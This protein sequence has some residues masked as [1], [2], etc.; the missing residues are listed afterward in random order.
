MFGADPPPELYQF[1]SSAEVPPEP[2]DVPSRNS[3]ALLSL[4]PFDMLSAQPSTPRKSRHRSH[5]SMSSIYS[6]P[7]MLSGDLESVDPS[8]TVSSRPPPTPPPFSAYSMQPP[9]L[10]IAESQPHA[11]LDLENSSDFRQRRLRAAKLSRFFGVTYQDIS[12]FDQPGAHTPRPSVVA[13]QPVPFDAPSSPIDVDVRIAEPNR[14][15]ARVE[16]RETMREPVDMGAVIHKLR[17]MR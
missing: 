14:F 3:A 15:W 17:T 2:V 10:P 12:S 16:R 1:S 6:Q 7:S 5:S 8:Q 4:P 13:P 9:P 11:A